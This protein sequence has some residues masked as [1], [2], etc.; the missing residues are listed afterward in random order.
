LR[1][2]PISFQVETI[3]LDCCSSSTVGKPS[4]RKPKLK[5]KYL[6]TFLI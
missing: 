5:L 2:L 6:Q 1:I 4:E 3:Y